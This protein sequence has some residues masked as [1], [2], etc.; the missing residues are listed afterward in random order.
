MQ[1]NIHVYGTRNIVQN[2]TVKVSVFCRSYKIDLWAFGMLLFLLIIN[3]DL[4]HSY[5]IDIDSDETSIGIDVVQDM[6]INKK[7]PT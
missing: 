7:H 3:P 2:V 1:G 5:E 6:L 4:T